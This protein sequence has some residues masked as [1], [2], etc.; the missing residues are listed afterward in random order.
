MIVHVLVSSLSAT[1]LISFFRAHER[2]SGIPY[3]E[4]DC[5]SSYLFRY[6][7]AFEG[8]VSKLRIPIRRPIPSIKFRRVSET[9][10]L[11][12]KS[13]SLDLSVV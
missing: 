8:D 3:R 11:L 5:V 2:I 12:L 9:L 10:V 6:G 7:L 4:G 13:R 1:L